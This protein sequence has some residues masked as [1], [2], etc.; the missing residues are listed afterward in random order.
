MDEEDLMTLNSADV[1]LEGIVLKLDKDMDPLKLTFDRNGKLAMI[2]FC[3]TDT[4][5]LNK[6]MTVKK[7]EFLYYPYVKIYT[8]SAAR[9]M[10]VVKVF[11]YL[12]KKYINDLEVIDTSGYWQN[13]DEEELKVRMWKAGTEKR[14]TF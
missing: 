6:K 8:P 5:G 13:R 9:H 4:I 11:D 7:Y 2:T 10:Q 3:T 1:Y 14:L 12:K